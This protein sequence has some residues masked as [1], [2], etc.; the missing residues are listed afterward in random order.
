M[1][2]YIDA[3]SCLQV[4]LGL[5]NENL[6]HD[7]RLTCWSLKGDCNISPG[8]GGRCHQQWRAR[9]SLHGLTCENWWQIWKNRRRSETVWVL[10]WSRTVCRCRRSWPVQNFFPWHCRFAAWGSARLHA[11][12]CPLTEI[13]NHHIV[14]GVTEWLEQ[15]W[16]NG[17][18]G[19][20]NISRN[21]ICPGGSTWWDLWNGAEQLFIFRELWGFVYGFPKVRTGTSCCKGPHFKK[22]KNVWLFEAILSLTYKSLVHRT[23]HGLGVD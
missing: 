21:T 2:F 9:V 16:A 5:I 6:P 23:W 7:A 8:I 20:L 19:Y 17:F 13:K 22:Q 15:Y 10:R 11:H 14:V 12:R 1:C 4:H 18:S 3:C